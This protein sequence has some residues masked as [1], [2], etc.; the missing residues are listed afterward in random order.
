MKH[1][2][3][4]QIREHDSK[5]RADREVVVTAWWTLGNVDR[6]RFIETDPARRRLSLQQAIRRYET[7]LGEVVESLDND[8]IPRS[9]RSALIEAG[10]TVPDVA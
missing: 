10:Y 5:F 7:G 2:P 1:K 9:V 3:K 8:G 4:I 6:Y